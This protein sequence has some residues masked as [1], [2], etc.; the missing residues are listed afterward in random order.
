MN[1]KLA[2]G[3]RPADSTAAELMETMPI[4]M[5][6]IRTEMRSQRG[7]ELSVPQFRLMAYLSRNPDSSLSEVAE[8]LG[9]T[10]ATAST[11]TDRLVQRG[12]VDRAD[13]PQARRQIMLRLTPTGSSQLEAMRSTTRQ[14]I[15]ELL[16]QL[17]P[18]EL[19]QISTGLTLLGQAFQIAK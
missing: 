1:A 16:S 10:R 2:A 12:L 11:M 6:F 9:V 15:A 7:A 3:K 13:D 17:S 18:E 5:Q 14:R 4:I 8:H 19:A